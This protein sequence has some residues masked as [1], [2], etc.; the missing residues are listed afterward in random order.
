MFTIVAAYTL[1]PP[2][3]KVTPDTSKPGFVWNYFA[4]RDPANT[5]NSNARAEADLALQAV[6]STGAL[7]P[8]LGD[9]NVVGAALAAAAPANPVNAPLHF[10]ISGVINLNKDPSVERGSF[11]TVNGHPDEQE[12][13]VPST[14]AT[15]D[16]QAAEILT[17]L[18]L[19]AGAIQMGLNRAAAFSPASAPGPR[20][21]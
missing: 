20:R 14:D 12:P 7:L 1:I 3:W 2:S 17:Y 9:P 19:P 21:D 18:T 16:G 5:G 6:D 11:T 13:G 10:E 15:T 8:N 4:N